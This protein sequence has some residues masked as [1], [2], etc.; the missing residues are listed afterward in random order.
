M[1]NERVYKYLTPEQAMGMKKV[2]R[3]LEVYTAGWQ[4]GTRWGEKRGWL[5]WLSLGIGSGLLTGIAV[6]YL[7]HCV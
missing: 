2:Q 6:A 4:E 5:V 1:I 7:V 3:D